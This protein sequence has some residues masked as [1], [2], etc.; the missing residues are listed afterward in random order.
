M[1]SEY[2]RKPPQF[3]LTR[4]IS[5]EEATPKPIP[6]KGGFGIWNIVQFLRN[7]YLFIRD[8]AI[9]L[10]S[11]VYKMKFHR[12]V[13]VLTDFQAISALYDHTKVEKIECFSNLLFNENC[14]KNVRPSVFTNNYEHEIKKDALLQYD[15][16]CLKNMNFNN[17]FELMLKEFE[18]LPKIEND[19]KGFDIEENL[20]DLIATVS[21]NVMLGYTVDPK[22]LRA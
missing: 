9:N 4:Y 19:P 5:A 11:T 3:N 10:N 8:N 17:I 21:V 14:L 18:K 20:E 13:I 1:D 15:A 16:F 6:W 2:Q 7:G 22:L 12:D